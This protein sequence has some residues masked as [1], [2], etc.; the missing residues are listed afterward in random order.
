MIR[1]RVLSAVV[2]VPVMLGL[3][4][5]GG[6]AW[7]VF[8]LLTGILAWGEMA[9]LLQQAHFTVRRNLGYFFIVGALLEAYGHSSGLLRVDLLRPLLA[10]LI[11]FS[12]I[13]AL[14]NKGEHATA[15]WGITVASALYLGFLLSHFVTLREFQHSN[16][17]AWWLSLPA[18]GAHPAGFNWVV[19]AVG[20]G[21]IT[22]A[23]A[24]F[25]GSA[26]GKH[27][28][29]PR[30]SPKKTWEGLAGGSLAC[31][32]TGVIA[33]IWLLNIGPWLGLLLGAL[34]AIFD[35]FGDFAVSLFKRMAHSKDSSQLIPGHGGVL[36]RLDS[37][38]FIIPMVTYFAQ[39]VTR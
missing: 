11:I 32:V 23:A 21:W 4:Y 30:I 35:P 27:Q 24:F 37:L 14:Y 17:A 20:L 25:V 33:G 34:V 18:A 29:W 1:A 19:A 28:M 6:I 16:G 31:L 36:D 15:D 22:D 9:Q 26:I 8:I 13:W 10:G 2:L 3:I 5:L 39:L 38:L 12:L 7:L